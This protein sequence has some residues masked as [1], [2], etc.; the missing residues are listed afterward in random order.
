MEV[1]MRNE[2][3]GMPVIVDPSVAPGTVHIRQVSRR[4]IAGFTCARDAR[5]FA[6][7]KREAGELVEVRPSRN[8]EMLVDVWT[9]VPRG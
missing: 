2:F 5:L 9:L 4:L 3:L 1:D 6:A 7:L 8:P